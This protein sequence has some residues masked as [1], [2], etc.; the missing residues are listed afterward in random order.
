MKHGASVLAVDKVGSGVKPLFDHVDGIE[1]FTAAL[2]NAAEL[3]AVVDEAVNR[4]GDLD[5]VIADFPLRANAPISD[6]DPELA[7][8]LRARKELTTALA[9][10]AIQYR[11]RA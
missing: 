10:A 7:R 2:T 1:G 3:P 6:D 9:A 8:L 5:I 11:L 4:L